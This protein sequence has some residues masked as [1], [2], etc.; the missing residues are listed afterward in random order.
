MYLIYKN[1]SVFNNVNIMNRYRGNGLLSQ[2]LIYR[3]WPF[4]RGK[5][6]N[7]DCQIRGI[8]N[9]IVLLN[10]Q[11]S[12]N[13][14]LININGGSNN[15]LSLGSMDNIITKDIITDGYKGYSVLKDFGDVQYLLNNDIDFNKLIYNFLKSLDDNN[16]YTLLSIVRYFNYES[17]QTE[18]LTIGSSIKV[19]N[20]TDSELVCRRLKMDLNSIVYRYGLPDSDLNLVVTG[21]IWLSNDE[22]NVR[23]A[24]ISESLNDVIKDGLKLHECNSR[25]D[26]RSKILKE[27]MLGVY[28]SVLMD[29]YGVIDGIS[30]NIS[31]YKYN[32]ELLE[33]KD[34][35]QSD[36]EIKKEVRVKFIGGNKIGSSYNIIS[37]IDT[38][39]DENSFI[40]EL[41]KVRFYYEKDK[42]IRIEG[43]YN[44][45]NIR[46]EAP[47]L[48][49]NDKIGCIDFETFGN[50]DNGFGEQKPF[51]GGWATTK[52]NNFCY[53]NKGESYDNLVLRVINSIFD[54]NDNDKYTFYAHNLGRFD[55]LIL[56]RG[57]ASSNVYKIKPL[58]KDNKILSIKIKNVETGMTIKL[59]DSLQILNGNLRD[60][61]QTYQ[62]NNL[63][64]IFPYR[65]MNEDRLFY[66]GSVPKIKYFDGID[67]SYYNSLCTNITE[68][69]AK[70]ECLN[71][72][73]NDVFGLLDV[74]NKVS[75]LFYD[76]YSLNITNYKTLPSGILAAYTC[77]YYN[78]D[79]NIKMTNGFI[80]KDIRTAYFGGNV[81]VFDHNIPDG[82]F[83]YDMNSQ[84]PNAML[85]DMPVGDPI[86]TNEKDITNFFGF[87]YG[88][89]YP[90]M[91]DI[92]PNLYIQY[93]DENGS[94]SC[95]RFKF[96][97]L[98]FSEEI[99]F[100]I[101]EGYQFEMEW[102]Y[103]FERGKGVFDKFVTEIYNEKRY[104][105][106][107]IVR[108]SRKLELNSLYGK[109]AQKKTNSVIKIMKKS[110]V[111]NI[112]KRFNYQY[113]ATLNNDLV[114]IKYNSRMNEKLRILYKNAL[115][116]RDQELSGLF[117]LSGIPSAVQI[118]AAISAYA[119]ISINKYKNIKGNKC[120]YSDTY[121]VIL[122]FDFCLC[123]HV[124]CEARI[125][126]VVI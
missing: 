114:L 42:I 22:F 120:Y 54:Y 41:G 86:H 106:N 16:T 25:T 82:A 27:D 81:D 109:F 60:I 113:I 94:V 95:P 3:C 75:K 14:N 76:K 61:L 4:F 5:T 57:L 73:S 118:S 28:K 124:I 91:K 23:K 68:W 116:Q 104:A 18:G 63:K 11:Q 108:N 88:T 48:L 49:Y 69:D 12:Q 65:F 8:H 121:S 101:K 90:P 15:V 36:G 72:L 70:S 99:K 7:F 125:D 51:A 45:P 97:R 26:N 62:C 40:R 20:E 21:R 96:K 77:N 44:F 17:G 43:L 47:D 110:E 9:N 71:Y 80:E 126:Y 35:S 66:K 1:S 117:K 32:E 119:R 92:L 87:A 105:S 58:W 115:S 33:V 30:G 78:E 85:Q 103:K 89:I 123:K 84:Y 34:L 122:R 19:N 102:G 67:I 111:K 112:T 38:R 100:A 53:I 107:P 29:N 93:R 46:C 31:Y 37:W 56:I 74:M 6:Y 83:M 64:G 50:K 13:N 39:I 98:I 79:F 59:L 52:Y 24:Q 55:A 2:H 10:S